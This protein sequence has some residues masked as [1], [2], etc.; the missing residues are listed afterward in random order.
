MGIVTTAH[1]VRSFDEM[2]IKQNI[3]TEY[4]GINNK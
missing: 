2:C 4:Q 1:I 3:F